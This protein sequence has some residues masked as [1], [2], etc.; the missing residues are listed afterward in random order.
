M[1]IQE[2]DFWGEIEVDGTVTPSM[3]LKQQASLLGVKTNHLLEAEVRTH[4]YYDSFR[5]SFDLVVPGLDN[6]TYEL[7]KVSHGA[8]LYP[9]TPLS[10]ADARHNGEELLTEDD[11]KRWVHHKLS[12]PD[13]KRIVANLLSMARS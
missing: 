1:T 10:E 13:T 7:F 2:P 9:V 8:K 4:T 12:S 3:I 11:F 5:H 6:Y